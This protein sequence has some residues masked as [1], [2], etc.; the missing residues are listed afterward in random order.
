MEGRGRG[1]E[2]F[3]D[4]NLVPEPTHPMTPPDLYVRKLSWRQKKGWNHGGKISISQAQK[5][6]RGLYLTLLTQPLQASCAA[7]KGR[8]GNYQMAHDSQL[9]SI[10]LNT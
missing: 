3:L 10:E 7:R 2:L 5:S 1:A 4:G 8:Y 9:P 6:R